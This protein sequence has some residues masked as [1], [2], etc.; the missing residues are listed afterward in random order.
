MINNLRK[1]PSSYLS[2]LLW[3]HFDL[4]IYLFILFKSKSCVANKRGDKKKSMLHIQTDVLTALGSIF[5]AMPFK[6]S[7]VALSVLSSVTN[8]KEKK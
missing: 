6:V 5:P 7:V 3:A 2:Q 8:I 1:H 4:F